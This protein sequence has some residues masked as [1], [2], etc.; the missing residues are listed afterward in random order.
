MASLEI[1]ILSHY[2]GLGYAA[3][4]AGVGRKLG[5]EP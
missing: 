1:I 5:V 3:F 4:V 2:V